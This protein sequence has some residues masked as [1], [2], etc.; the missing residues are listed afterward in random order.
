MNKLR[1]LCSSI[2]DA[3]CCN[4]HSVL[5]SG[6]HWHCFSLLLSKL[7]GVG[8]IFFSS[9]VKI[10]QILKI[11]LHMRADGISLIAILMELPVNVISFCYHYSHHYAWTTYAETLI[12]FTQNLIIGFFVSR[13][14]NILDSTIWNLIV[15]A[16]C[17]LIFGTLRNIIP[18]SF[19]L[20]L[21]FICVPLSIANKFPQIILSY[22]SKKRGNFSRT[23]S[24]L[25]AL[26]SLGRV[27][28]TLREIND[29][30][31]LIS[32]LLNFSLTVIIFVQSLIY[33][34]STER[35]L[36]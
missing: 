36:K 16:H 11:L 24:F 19:I 7:I 5:L 21:W 28:T 13:L 17:S 30:S 33:P 32:S 35:K 14:E 10:P 22:R 31:V 26:G 2:L 3:S 20:P 4:I 25:R 27:L 9:L 8:L 6:S 34:V 12:V 29:R 18:A 15:L 1:E 23:S